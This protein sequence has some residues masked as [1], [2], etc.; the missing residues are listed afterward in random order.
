MPPRR[1]D[2]HRKTG[3][4]EVFILALKIA[5]RNPLGS[6]KRGYKAVVLLPC[7]RTVDIVAV[8]SIIARGPKD[9]GLIDRFQGHNG[10]HGI[11][12]V[13]LLLPREIG[14]A[15]GQIGRG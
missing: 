7:Q 9:L 8:A 12:K 1:Q 15:P 3:F 2:L 14:N 5:Q 11:I 10:R 6:H 13:E 4:K